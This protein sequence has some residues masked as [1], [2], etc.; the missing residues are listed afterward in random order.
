MNNGS[1]RI[2]NLLEV[3]DVSVRFGGLC[4]LDAVSLSVDAGSIVGLIG[5]NGA[6]KTTL[7]N[8]IT[9]VV[10]VDAG[11]IGFN[12]SDITSSSPQGRARLGMARSFQNLGLVLDESVETNLMAALHLSATYP[13]LSPILRPGRTRR[14]EQRCRAQVVEVLDRFELTE[15]ARS[16]VA[17]LSFGVARMVEVAGLFARE[18]SVLLLDEPT[19]GLDPSE[20]AT[21]TT[22]LASARATGVGVLVIAHDVGFI[23]ELCDEVVVLAEGR[24]IYR[25]D[26]VGVRH[27]ERVV[28]SYLGGA[29]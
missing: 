2:D 12:G 8:A 27:D 28:E 22:A 6:G 1:D 14:T 13:P 4:A 23:V 16:P 24:V 26:P 21:L 18:A 10:A 5:P 15:H 19:T 3:D 7:L 29:A 9:G 17:D 25:G 11:R 20:I